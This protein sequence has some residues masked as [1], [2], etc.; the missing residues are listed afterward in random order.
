MFLRVAG[1]FLS[2]ASPCFLYENQWCETSDLHFNINLWRWGRKKHCAEIKHLMRRQIPS[3]QR[4][5]MQES[6]GELVLK[7][8]VQVSS[9]YIKCMNKRCQ[10]PALSFFVCWGGL[11]WCTM[12]SPVDIRC[13]KNTSDWTRDQR[14]TEGKQQ[15]GLYSNLKIWL[16]RAHKMVSQYDNASESCV[17]EKCWVRFSFEEVSKIIYF[18]RQNLHPLSFFTWLHLGGDSIERCLENMCCNGSTE[19]CQIK[20]STKG[21]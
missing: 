6:R 14:A 7:A 5:S 20:T 3:I 4:F 12:K 16:K 15:R 21:T 8:I 17:L 2:Q 9:Y 10:C 18:S 11:F 19:I 1:A 13:V